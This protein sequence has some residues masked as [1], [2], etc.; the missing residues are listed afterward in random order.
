MAGKSRLMSGN[1]A[2]KS[3]AKT[4]MEL[5]KMGKPMDEAPAI[6]GE[7]QGMPKI[8]RAADDS[9]RANAAIGKANFQKAGVNVDAVFDAL[10]P[11]HA[12]LSEKVHTQ[13]AK[14]ERVLTRLRSGELVAF[15][16]PVHD[17]DAILPVAVPVF[18]F[19]QTFAK[20][21]A[22]SF[23]GYGRRYIDVT[24]SVLEPG[25]PLQSPP[26][27]RVGAPAFTASL[28]II[29]N[30]LTEKGVSFDGPPWKRVGHLFR[31]AGGELALSKFDETHPS[32]ET[33]RRFIE[34]RKPSKR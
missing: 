10:I 6:F 28:E 26:A 32:N 1:S 20:W 30:L 16:F 27:K 29:A 14:G 12:A 9:V 3:G 25:T 34:S 18:L 17:P 31:T 5:W 22:R 8:R 19:D 7:V 24:V 4:A 11:I 33:V 2:N 21:G 13:A 15:G 23:V